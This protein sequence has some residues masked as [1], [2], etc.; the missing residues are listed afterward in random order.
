MLIDTR[1]MKIVLALD[2]DEPAV[3]FGKVDSFLAGSP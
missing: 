1:T 3:L 2:G